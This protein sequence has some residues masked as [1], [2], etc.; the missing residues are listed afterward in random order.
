MSE[1]CQVALASTSN[2]EDAAWLAVA[3][4]AGVVTDLGIDYRLIGGNSVALLVQVH[5]AAAQVPGR[6][7][8]DADMGASF[9]VC[10]DPRLVPALTGLGYDRQSGNRFTRT[11][12]T[13]A[14]VIDVLAPSYLGRLIPNQTHGDLVLDE[15]PGLLDALLLPPVN[16]A[17]RAV[18]TDTT[19]LYVQVP[20]PD[21]RAA[22]VMKAHA[23]AGRLSDKRRPGYLAAPPIGEQRRA[24]RGRLAHQEHGPRRRG[25]PAPALRHAKKRRTTSGHT[26]PHQPGADPRTDRPGRPEP[27]PHLRP[28]D[29]C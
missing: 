6:A 10:A 17:A 28:E 14:L 1:P 19:Q 29:R 3:D 24:H 16:V 13:R 26:E 2:A 9:E 20:L 11:Q 18:L 21:V 4:V 15:I 23:Y 8:A 27:N 5:D 7:T 22:L 12:G 25:D